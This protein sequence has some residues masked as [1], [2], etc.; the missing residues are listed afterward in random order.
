MFTHN[1]AIIEVKRN[2]RQAELPVL[3]SNFASNN[4]SRG[5]AAVDLDFFFFGCILFTTTIGTRAKTTNA[6]S[7][8]KCR[9]ISEK[10]G[11]TPATTSTDSQCHFHYSEPTIINESVLFCFVASPMTRQSYV[12]HICI[13]IYTNVCMYI[14]LLSTGFDRTQ[15]TV[16]VDT[17]EGETQSRAHARN[18]TK[19]FNK[20][21][22]PSVSSGARLPIRGP[23][24]ISDSRIGGRACFVPTYIVILYS[25]T[26][27]PG[28]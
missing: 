28:P 14:I 3:L 27:R 19:P 13:C 10:R 15:W 12:Y 18:N 8:S 11:I 26:R 9:L 1:R 24:V 7:C 17:V 22:L 16:C 4:N 25:H 21:Q 2:D 23:P 6:I 5:P 20:K